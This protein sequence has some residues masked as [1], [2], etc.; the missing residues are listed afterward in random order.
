MKKIF[1][2]HKS[3]INYYSELED[4]AKVYFDK[5]FKL[6]SNNKIENDFQNILKKFITHFD[7]I[8]KFLSQSIEEVTVLDDCYTEL[9]KILDVGSNMD[10]HDIHSNID[11]KVELPDRTD[12]TEKTIP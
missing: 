6:I 12:E 3:S 9:E 5:S 11:E 1:D 7:K 4:I 10:E 8:E 2:I